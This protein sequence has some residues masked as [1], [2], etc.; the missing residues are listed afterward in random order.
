MAGA[1]WLR[2]GRVRESCIGQEADGAGLTKRPPCDYKTANAK[3]SQL[4]EK[5]GGRGFASL[6][7]PET[8]IA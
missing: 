3:Q 7:S 2:P 6:Q 1:T 8:P 5:I 4:Q